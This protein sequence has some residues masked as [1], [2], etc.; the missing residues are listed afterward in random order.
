M[1]ISS[2]CHRIITIGFAALFGV[3]PLLLTP[4]NYELFEYNKMMAVYAL[5]VIIVGAWIIKMIAQREIRI[6]RTPLDIPILLFLG[7]QLL[8]SLFSIDPHV[9]WFG[10]YSRF[11]G[12][13]LSIISYVLLFYAFISNWTNLT[14]LTNLIK[15]ALGTGTV[16]AV[17]GVA[18]RLGV[19][20]HLWV[21]DVQN[22]VFSTLGQP[23]W[24]AAYLVALAPLT[25]A[26]MLQVQS[27][28]FKV[29]SFIGGAI[30]TL[31]FIVLLFTRSRSG[32]FGFA[33]ADA[34][35]WALVLRS[36]L[37]PEKVR[38]FLAF[39][40]L[41]S[42]F[43][44]VIFFNGTHVEAIDRW[45]TLESWKNRFDQQTTNN[46]QQTTPSQIQG[47]L[48]EYGGTESGKIRKYVW[49]AAINAWQ[50]STKAKLIGT[51][52][53][54]FAFAFFRYRPVE[55]NLTS[56][57]DFLYNKAHN[58]YLNYLATTGLLGLGSYLLFI[59]AFII[60]FLKFSIFKFQ[61]CLALF[62]GWVS[63][64]VTNFFGFSVV[65]TNLFLFLF[66]AMIFVISDKPKMI[67]RTI[68]F[69]VFPIFLS[70][71]LL[72]ALLAIH[73]YAD[74]QFA[75]GYRFSHAGE[76]SSAIPL[77]KKAVDLNPIEPLYH[78]EYAAALAGLAQTDELL[79]QSLTE[80]DKALATSPQNVNFW[81]TR[82]KIFY[83]YSNL[84]PQ[85]NKAAIEALEK[86]GSLAPTD[87]KVFYNLAIL[88]GRQED[89]KKSI[90]LLEKTIS[91]KAN[92]RDAYYALWVFYTETKQPQK[93]RE[94]LQ[95]YLT[96]V[97]PGDKDFIERIKQ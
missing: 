95:N 23:N 58:E 39:V 56:E 73:W 85:W 57:W 84:D 34:I 31:L 33:V 7:S 74:T 24:L 19:D 18:E 28:K 63:I 59:G 10:Y 21:Q 6:S 46:K 93:A 92:Y 66:P 35:F 9:S 2:V 67:R 86:A 38:P 8:S 44:L 36:H 65:V 71:L 32:L 51:G 3:V 16:V 53:E 76:F 79:R 80:N 15:V 25:W 12:G 26:L 88:Y 4:W 78:D 49:Q 77:L 70:Q 13:M 14:Y 83:S 94:I 90:E 17:F 45:M 69:P 43:L 11:N 37:W 40:I 72:L 42:A 48:L 81:K 64:L 82:T 68:K 97:D 52:T 55:H 87:P 62:A 30:A 5:T 22:R 61:I 60:W 29:Q 27:S 50:S 20:K 1:N 41:H 91:L 47:T 54:T 89:N 96:K 75:S